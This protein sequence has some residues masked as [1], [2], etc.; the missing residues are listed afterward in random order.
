MNRVSNIRNIQTLNEKELVSGAAGDYTKSWHRQYKDSAWI[1]INGLSYD[2]TEGDIIAV[3]SQYGEV[4]NINLVRDPKTG[5]SKG[6]CFLCYQDQRSTILA[7]DNL[8]G[9]NLC[10]RIIKVDHV[11]S[12]KVPKYKESL[13]TETRKI[14][15]KG[16][17]P[18]PIKLSAKEIEK[19]QKEE[20]E[21]HKKAIQKCAEVLPFDL[22]S[23]DPDLL[24]TM[25]KIKK[26]EKKEA[27]R[28]ERLRKQEKRLVDAE[29]NK[30]DPDMIDHWSSK[31]VK[32][33]KIIGEKDLYNSNPNFMFNKEKK[34]A[35][36][37]PTHNVRPDFEKADWRDVELFKI[38][39][40]QDKMVHG[41]KTHKW[42]ESEAFIP[43]RLAK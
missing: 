11:E 28:E 18:E 41:E 32:L 24:K 25:K 29:I 26:R 2:L 27:K 5:K 10:K 30:G 4:V 16:C 9:I 3:F 39:R 8:N 31:R 14:M 38:V 12:Y 6:F 20:N 13:D 7:V 42:K 34:L 36:P 21:R 35:P 40:E 19:L 22:D 43:K 23:V 33:D 17:A 37:P 1:H 15:E